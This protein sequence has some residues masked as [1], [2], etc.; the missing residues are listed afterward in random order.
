MNS[1]FL[2]SMMAITMVF[3]FG[4]CSFGAK[5]TDTTG[6]TGT[7]TAT[8]TDTATTTDSAAKMAPYVV[9]EWTQ[10]EHANFNLSYPKDWEMQENV[11][12]TLVAV[13]SPVTDGDLF[14]ENCNVVLDDSA[15]AA[16]YSA[17]DYF[18]AS[19]GQLS[20][21][22]TGYEEIG[23]GE[24]QVGGKEGYYIAYNGVQGEYGLSWVQY[25]TKG[26]SNHYILTCT[27]MKESFAAYKDAFDQLASK[28]SVK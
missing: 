9:S 11:Y 4:A 25:L 2:L 28:M 20:S 23:R 17:K 12:G 13:L 16:D 14:S 24:I 6:T 5:D 19:V 7:N 27:S 22:I 1:K 8:V 3:G 18:D 15:E 26:E 21:F 10:Y